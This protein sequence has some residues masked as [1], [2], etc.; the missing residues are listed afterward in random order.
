MSNPNFSE[1]VRTRLELVLEQNQSN[2]HKVAQKTGI[3][4]NTVYRATR[5]PG[6]AKLEHLHRI[7]TE[8]GTSVHEL[9]AE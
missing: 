9:V 6:E 5:N 8:L 4:V 2:P 7:A 3:A 1:T